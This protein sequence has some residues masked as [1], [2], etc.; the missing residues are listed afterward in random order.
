LLEES[1]KRVVVATSRIEN[2]Q[3]VE[4]ELDSH[5]PSNVLVAA[6]LTGRPNV[7]WC[8][9]NREATV[10]VNVCGTINVAD[11]CSTRSIHCTIFATGAIKALR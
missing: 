6:G 3:D 2:R 4:R 1:G 9:T 8:E 5:K 10:R 7:D 11:L